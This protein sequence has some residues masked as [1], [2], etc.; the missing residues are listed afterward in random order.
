M[1]ELQELQ[2]AII[3]FIKKV[4]AGSEKA[5]PAELEAATRL[6]E[7]LASTGRIY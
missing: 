6:A 1:K 2:D 4:L 7:L 5:S 3:E